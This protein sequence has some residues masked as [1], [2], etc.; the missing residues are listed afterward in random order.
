MCAHPLRLGDFALCQL[1]EESKQRSDQ[2]AR[3]LHTE[4]LVQLSVGAL[5]GITLL[6]LANNRPSLKWSVL[7]A[8]AASPAE[9]RAFRVSAKLIIIMRK[10]MARFHRRFEGSCYVTQ[11]WLQEGDVTSMFNTRQRSAW[12]R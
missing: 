8:Q 11:A 12:Q 5:L 3:R 6:Q 4:Y 1:L 2:W 10:A 9:Y 7:R